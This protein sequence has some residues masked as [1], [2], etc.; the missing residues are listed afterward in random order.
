M[1]TSD[2]APLLPRVSSGDRAA[3]QACV[4]RYGSL[5]WTIAIR[6]LRNESD[7]DDATQDTFLALWQS[8]ARFDPSR[9]NERTFVAMIARRRVVDKKRSADRQ[10]REASSSE[11]EL[12][13]VPNAAYEELERGPDAQRVVDALATLPA[14]RRN[15]LHLSVVNGLTHGE[16]AQ[17]T[18]LALGTVKSHV[19][20]GLAAVR[21]LLL[22]NRGSQ[23]TKEGRLSR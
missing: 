20:R 10:R 17:E 21:E 14:D 5:V 8:A 6:I 9:S 13:K 16:I 2:E 22:G 3:M 4:D 23:E 15:V 11:L 7:A 1:T 18:G 19:R 12:S